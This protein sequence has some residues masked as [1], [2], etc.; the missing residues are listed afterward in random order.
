LPNN[1]DETDL[2]IEAE[3]QLCLIHM[4]ELDEIQELIDKPDF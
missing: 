2:D 4:E 1:D 3:R